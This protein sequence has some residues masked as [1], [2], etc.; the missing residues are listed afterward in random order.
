MQRQVVDICN[1]HSD[2]EQGLSQVFPKR[3]EEVEK[4]LLVLV[5][6]A[7]EGQFSAVYS[8][9][10]VWNQVF[11][12][13]VIAF[14]R[15]IQN[16]VFFLFLYYSEGF[17]PGFA[18]VMFQSHAIVFTEQKLDIKNSLWQL[19]GFEQ[20]PRKRK[21][22]VPLVL[23]LENLSDPLDHVRA[24][25]DLGIWR[26][27]FVGELHFALVFVFVGVDGDMTVGQVLSVEVVQRQVFEAHLGKAKAQQGFVRVLLHSQSVLFGIG[28][29]P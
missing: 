18:Q 1:D 23:R 28:V 10:R 12:G 19:K 15:K 22:K 2:F 11:V 14:V 13:E 7:A 16:D 3:A 20:T 21:S 17:V 25:F 4:K 27:D 29:Q 8:G 9:K 24:D 26:K 6:L 5:E